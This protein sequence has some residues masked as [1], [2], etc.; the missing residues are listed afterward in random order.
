MWGGFSSKKGLEKEERNQNLILKV[1]H[2]LVR[3]FDSNN[4]K[5]VPLDSEEDDDDRDDE[6]ED[7]DSAVMEESTSS[8]P[9][10]REIY[11]FLRQLYRM[12]LLDMTMNRLKI[13]R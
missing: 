7:E 5:P 2:L 6:D 13:W 10:L 9:P 3:A 12:R 4:L 11:G 8:Q 1:C